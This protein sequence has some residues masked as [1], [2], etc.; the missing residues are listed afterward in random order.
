[1]TTA[2]TPYSMN[3]PS[4]PSGPM[5]GVSSMRTLA[6][7]G[8]RGGGGVDA[9]PQAL[10]RGLQQGFL[11]RIGRRQQDPLARHALAQVRLAA[12]GQTIGGPLLAEPEFAARALAGG[13]QHAIGAVVQRVFDERRRQL[14]G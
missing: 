1:M 6:V 2:N 4:Q 9:L 11:A 12:A 13:D 14:A 3:W 8:H 10:Q 5:V 7:E